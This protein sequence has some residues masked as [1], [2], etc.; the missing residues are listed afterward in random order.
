MIDIHSHIIFDVDDGPKTLEDS[1]RLIKDSYEQGVRSIIATSHRRKGM[2]ETAEDNIK[3]NFEQLKKEVSL[4]YKDLQ[5]Y[6]GA[7]IYYTLDVV[8]KIE[9][10]QYPTL[11]NTKFVLIEFSGNTR[12]SEIEQAVTKITLI[13]KI[14]IL[15]HI[16]RYTELAND[17]KKL[18]KLIKR[19]AYIQINAASVLR[20]KLFGDKEK[21]YKKRARF[22]LENELVH[23]IASDMHNV[24]SR[25]CYMAEAYRVVDEKYGK[26][27]ADEIFL[28]NQ[29]L[30]LKNIK[31]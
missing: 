27:Y 6:Y 12:F 4:Q 31:I 22:F 2:F 24:T 17:K 29:Q 15:A 9:L 23:F 11:A 18:E 28:E 26:D 30:L 19:G 3:S 1:M 7:E 16:E 8:E 5:L 14:P 13:G 20:P 10:G 21:I 25:K